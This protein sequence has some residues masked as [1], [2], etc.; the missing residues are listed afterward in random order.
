MMLDAFVDRYVIEVVVI[1]VI[2][3]GLCFLSGRMSR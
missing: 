3:G 2:Y 1:A